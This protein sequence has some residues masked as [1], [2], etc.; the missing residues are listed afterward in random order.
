MVAKPAEVGIVAAPGVALVTLEEERYRL[1]AAV[2]ESAIG[3]IRIGQ[4]AAVQIDALDRE[5]DGVVVEVVPA[6][7][8]ATRTVLVKVELPA[9]PR[10]RSGLCGRARFAVGERTVLTVPRAALVERGQLQGVFVVD[11]ARR[12]RLRLVKTG[13]ALGERVEILSGLG[14]GERVVVEGLP[15]LADGRLVDVR[16]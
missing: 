5:R 3:R 9:A 7:D 8:P 2:P 10:L 15:G 1:E 4:G 12:A 16:E 6:A 14:D 11:P 13:R